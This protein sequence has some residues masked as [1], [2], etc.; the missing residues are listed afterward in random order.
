M[1]VLLVNKPQSPKLRCGDT[2]QMEKTAETLRELR[3]EVIISTAPEPDARGFD[4]VQIFNLRTIDATERQ[5][6]AL[7]RQ[8][9]PIVMSPIYL[10]VSEPLWGSKAVARARR[11]KVTRRVSEAT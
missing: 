3:V 4:I 5:V 11:A 9:L 6:A 1:R 7:A 2:V 8:G 10:D